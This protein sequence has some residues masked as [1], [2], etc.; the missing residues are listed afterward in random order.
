[1]F[2]LPG[3]AIVMYITKQPIEDELK[4]EIIRY[5]SNL[6]TEEGGWGIHIESMSTVFGT[7]LNY[8]TMR[9]L[10]ISSQDDRLLRARQWLEERGG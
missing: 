1:M 3:F 7:V 6:Q 5:L 4:A 9:L 10:G 8:V 2:L